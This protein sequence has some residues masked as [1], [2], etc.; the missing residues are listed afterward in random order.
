MIWR[1]ELSVIKSSGRRRICF[2]VSFSRS[3][4]RKANSPQRKSIIIFPDSHFSD[5]EEERRPTLLADYKCI[6]GPQD[7]FTEDVVLRQ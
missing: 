2:Y 5:F 3:D 1:D 7:G 6:T 4:F